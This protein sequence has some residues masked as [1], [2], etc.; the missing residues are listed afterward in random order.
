MFTAT[1]IGYFPIISRLTLRTL[2][3]KLMLRNLENTLYFNIWR[4]TFKTQPEQLTKMQ[5]LGLRL[6]I[7]PATLDL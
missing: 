1:P 2:H 3:G 7:E 4:Y 6:E 5:L